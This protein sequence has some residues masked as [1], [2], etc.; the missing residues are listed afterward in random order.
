VVTPAGVAQIYDIYKQGKDRNTPLFITTDSV[1]HAYHIL[2][3]YVLRGVEL[4]NLIAAAKGLSASMLVAAT[5]VP[6]GAGA[7]EGIGARDAGLLHCCGQIA[8]CVT[9]VPADVR[10]VVERNWPLIEAHQGYADSPLFGYKEDYSQYAPRGHYTR[11]DQFKAYFKAMMWYGRIGFRL[12]PGK[13]AEQIALG[14][15]ES[16]RALLIV[17][18][19]EKSTVGAEPALKVWDRIYGPT[20][21]FVGPAMT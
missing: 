16:R 9:A 5:A 17:A 3:D 21:F 19:L 8:R 15:E 12:Q 2:Y 14:R 18:A 11:N 4:G 13:T 20:A 6:G 1:L 10:T 7:A